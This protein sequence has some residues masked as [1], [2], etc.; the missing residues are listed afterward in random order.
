MTSNQIQVYFAI[1]SFSAGTIIAFLCLF[2][3]EPY[4][5][6]SNS[7]L[8]AVSEFLILCGA[9]LGIKCHFDH[10]LNQFEAQINKKD[11]EDGVTD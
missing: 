11:K 6:I 5:E 3:V 8:S 4:G 2:A 1:A 9:L 7:A 10:R